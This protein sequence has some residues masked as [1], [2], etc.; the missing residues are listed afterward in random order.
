MSHTLGPNDGVSVTTKPA[1]MAQACTTV[2]A[3]R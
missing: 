2:V 1:A 3:P